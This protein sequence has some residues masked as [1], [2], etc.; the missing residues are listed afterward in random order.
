MAVNAFDKPVKTGYVSQYVKAP[1]QSARKANKR[2]QERSDKNRKRV[3]EFNREIPISAASENQE[4]AE[5]IQDE[6]QERV[7]GLQ[8]DGD[9]VNMNKDV[10]NL[11]SDYSKDERIKELERAKESKEEV[12]KSIDER[13]DLN[14]KQKSF[15]KKNLT[16]SDLQT[17]EQGNPSVSMQKSKYQNT[18]VVPQEDLIDRFKTAMDNNEDGFLKQINNRAG[19]NYNSLGEARQGLKQ[20]KVS[21]TTFDNA[22]NQLVSV[23]DTEVRNSEE[24]RAAAQGYENPEDARRVFETIEGEEGEQRNVFVDDSNGQVAVRGTVETEDGEEVE[25]LVNKKG[26]AVDRERFRRKLNTDSNLGRLVSGFALGQSSK[27]LDAED[28]GTASSNSSNSTAFSFDNF[29]NK[30]TEN[31]EQVDQPNTENTRK[32]KRFLNDL[33]RRTNIVDFSEHEDDTRYST[34]ENYQRSTIPGVS[35]G[36]VNLDAPMVAYEKPSRYASGM[37][38]LKEEGYSH[39]EAREKMATG[40]R[41]NQAEEGE[42]KKDKFWTGEDREFV[43]K[44]AQ[45]LFDFDE[46]WGKDEDMK[47]TPDQVTEVARVYKQLKGDDRMTSMNLRDVPNNVI[48]G[49]EGNDGTGNEG[50]TEALLTNQE[51]GNRAVYNAETGEVM[52]NGAFLELVHGNPDDPDDDGASNYNIT[53][54]VDPDNP[55]TKIANDQ[56]FAMS[57]QAVVDGQKY[58]IA[59]AE[60]EEWTVKDDQGKPQR[61][62]MATTARSISRIGHGKYSKGETKTFTEGFEMKTEEQGVVGYDMDVQTMV[63]QKG[64]PLYNVKVKIGDR[65]ITTDKPVRSPQVAYTK[66]LQKVSRLSEEESNNPSDEESAQGNRPTDQQKYKNGGEIENKNNPDEEE[67]DATVDKSRDSKEDKQKSLKKELSQQESLFDPESNF[68]PKSESDS[69]GKKAPP[70]NT[71]QGDDIKSPFKTEQFIGWLDKKD[72]D[73]GGDGVTEKDV[74]D[75]FTEQ[76]ILDNG[77][78]LAKLPNNVVED[79]DGNMAPDFLYNKD[80]K[81]P[82]LTAFRKYYK[83]SPYTLGENLPTEDGKPKKGSRRAS[84]CSDA[85]CNVV[86]ATSKRDDFNYDPEY[87]SSGEL[88]RISEKKEVGIENAQDGDYVTFYNEEKGRISHVGLIVVDQET[89]EKYLAD[90]NASYNGASV[91]P[92]ETRVKD[93]TSADKFKKEKVGIHRDTEYEP[94]EE[95]GATKEKQAKNAINLGFVDRFKEVYGESPYKYHNPE[96]S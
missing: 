57:Y 59:G 47:L 12:V 56:N 89:G 10:A 16:L 40:G 28:G 85:A 24:F 53:G 26:E 94:M 3:M 11:V 21:G 30:S 38:I 8:T 22:M 60:T 29:Y 84:D 46:D 45:N 39:K 93:V 88:K 65:E 1:L 70:G 35:E 17:D 50:M 96:Q 42:Y 15:L 32:A 61:K 27:E 92:F 77:D 54:V 48:A 68:T 83:K 72:K 19:T 86:N 73:K 91:M 36:K 31:T 78:N 95:V 52:E 82:T 69:N 25:T 37:R 34:G 81:S 87:T 51:A 7:D 71:Q 67:S 14:P 44:T 62:N 23:V 49:S 13:D 58:Y 76:T 2:L 9:F 20:G 6:Y 33:Q 41:F 79:G 63:D 75:F 18:G 64:D 5:R 74:R 55:I 4:D 90:Q 43:R 80:I 66:L